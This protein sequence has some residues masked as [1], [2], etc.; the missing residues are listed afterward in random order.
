VQQE[1]ALRDRGMTTLI[2]PAVDAGVKLSCASA[3]AAEMRFDQ[4]VV[5]CAVCGESTLGTA[6][7]RVSLASPVMQQLAI[8]V[9]RECRVAAVAEEHRCAHTVTWPMSVAPES[10]PLAINPSYVID[11]QR[12]DRYTAQSAA[13]VC[14]G[15]YATVSRVAICRGAD[16]VDALDDALREH[17]LHYD[18]DDSFPVAADNDGDGRSGRASVQPERAQWM[19]LQRRRLASVPKLSSLMFDIGRVPDTLPEPTIPEAQLLGLTRVMLLLQINAAGRQQQSRGQAIMFTHEGLDPL[20]ADMAAQQLESMG[21]TDNMVPALRLIPGSVGVCLVGPRQDCLRVCGNTRASRQRLVNACGSVIQVRPAVVFAWARFLHAVH[22]AY[23]DMLL[24][25]ESDDAHATLAAI[26]EQ[27]VAKAQLVTSEEC[28]NVEKL[29]GVGFGSSTKDVAGVRSTDPADNLDD[30]VGDGSSESLNVVMCDAV[31]VCGD[32]GSV[33][34][35]PEGVDPTTS[36]RAALAMLQSDTAAAA[37][38]KSVGVA[39]AAAVGVGAHD[40]VGCGVAGGTVVA[41]VGGA[42]VGVAPVIVGVVDERLPG[43]NSSAADAGGGVV[44][45]QQ[46]VD[47]AVAGTVPGAGVT[48]GA[49]NRVRPPVMPERPLPHIHRDKLPGNEFLMSSHLLTTAFAT[50][51]VLGS[52]LPGG[53]SMSRELSRHLLLQAHQRF[54]RNLRFIFLMHNRWLRHQAALRVSLRVKDGDTSFAVLQEVMARPTIVSE[55]QSAIEDPCSESARALQRSIEPLVTSVAQ[56]IPFTKDARGAVLVKELAMVRA[57]GLPSVFGTISP[58]DSYSMF[59][60]R[61]AHRPSS[62]DAVLAGDGVELQFLLPHA[63]QRAKLMAD[64]PVATSTFFM[65]VV[66]CVCL[67]LLRISPDAFNARGVAALRHQLR[68]QYLELA[69]LRHAA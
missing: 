37:P 61:F 56:Q 8:S 41:G 45:A 30:S 25:E 14:A 48:D 1:A 3:Y 15:C 54:A 63:A 35:P 18:V 10:R 38:S 20:T 36:L 22:P 12:G 27:L 58:A 42:A 21:G 57:F 24:R 32:C 7:T 51:F 44:S 60:L 53:V 62:P 9:A 34:A 33:N 55:L 50:I 2:G 66:K 47:P 31:M 6:V 49:A 23:R 52:Q 4:A 59:A 40:G 69:M 11:L 29:Y 28:I 64:N 16:G 26:P 67:H 39:A 5:G 65:L 19:A 68:S 13:N 43:G 17:I 46:A